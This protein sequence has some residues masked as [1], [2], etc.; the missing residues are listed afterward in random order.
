M[1][2]LMP[3]IFHKLPQLTLVGVVDILI[4][5]FVIYQILLIIRGTRAV[6]V[7]LGVGLLVLV[8]YGA[9]WGRLQ[10]IQWLLDKIFPYLVFALIV[11]FQ[12]EIRRGLAKIGRNPFNTR[13]AS[14]EV[15]QASEDI[16]MAASLFSSRRIGALIVLER[17]TGLRTF[18]ESGIPLQARLSYDLLI[19]IFQPGSPLH[20]GAVIIRKDKIVAASCFLPLSVNPVLGTQ[21][22]TR[23]RAAIGI[24]EE[25][26]AVA[27]AVSEE[28]GAISLAVGGSFELNIT[29]E[30]LAQRLSELFQ[31]PL[32][33]AS[34]PAAARAAGTLLGG[35]SPASTDSMPARNRL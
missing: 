17:T 8:Y 16:V 30:R 32:S 3:A 10:T 34:A 26:D 33:P 9:V 31:Y 2:F 14:L 21:L 6:Q 22:G 15:R 19:A 29:P 1:A 4:L 35:T 11:M 7:M 24:T 25:T 27:V 23:H 28:T 13:F 18:T 20:D 5:A 12:A